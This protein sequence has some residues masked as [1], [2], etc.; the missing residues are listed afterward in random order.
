MNEKLKEAFKAFLFNRGGHQFVNDYSGTEAEELAINFSQQYADEQAL[1]FA[2]W[3][4]GKDSLSDTWTDQE[5][6]TR[7][8]ESQKP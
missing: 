8:H 4:T 1:G 5:L 3:V 7:Y 2:K 6:L